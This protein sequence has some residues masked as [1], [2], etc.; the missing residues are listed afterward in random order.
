[1]EAWQI[2]LLAMSIYLI[3]A[4]ALGLAAGRGRSL[5]SVSEYAVGDRGFSLFVMWFLMGGTIFSAFSFLGG[6]GW[7]FSKGAASLYILAYCT[8]G[9]LPWYI[10][11]LPWSL[12]AIFHILVIT[13]QAFIFMVLTIMYISLASEEPH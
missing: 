13:L 3:L 12:W 2:A 8:L 9:L 7:A 5:F 1:M 10:I 6:P 11:P 4:F